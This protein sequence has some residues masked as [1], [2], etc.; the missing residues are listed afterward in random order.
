MHSDR[1][2]PET[3]GKTRP[4]EIKKEKKSFPSLLSVH[5]QPAHVCSFY[6]A[7]TF[8]GVPSR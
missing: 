4:P 7:Q 3:G 1:H 6:Q 5:S 2:I 8:R